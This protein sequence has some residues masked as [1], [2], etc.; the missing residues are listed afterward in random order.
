MKYQ[1]TVCGQIIDKNDVCPI[2]GSDSDKIFEIADEQ[3]PTMYR[4]LSC[5]RVFEN[6][7]VCPF[8]GG[9]E[10]YDLTND[11]IFD[12]NEKK[13]EEEPV[14][15][16]EEPID[17]FSQNLNE[18]ETFEDKTVDISKVTIPEEKEE[19]H[20]EI[21]EEDESSLI[22]DDDYENGDIIVHEAERNDEKEDV[23]LFGEEENTETLL[24][25]TISNEEIEESDPFEDLKLE[26][27]EEKE[28]EPQEKVEEETPLD[29]LSF[30]EDEV[31]EEVKEEIFEEPTIE[32][33]P[34]IE[35]ETEEEVELDTHVE[36][37]PIETDDE[38][39]V[40]KERRNKI[41]DQIIISSLSK[42]KDELD[43][44]RLSTVDALILNEVFDETNKVNDLSSDDLVTLF[45]E[46]Y[47][48]DKEIFEK[49][50]T[51]INGYLVF[52]DE[53]LLKEIEKGNK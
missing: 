47:A 5:G 38:I 27:E 32:E 52:K 28:E 46:K 18:E 39:D 30:T 4:C 15:V 41:I 10:L 17:L 1:C 22:Q 12:R 21:V 44:S 53:E 50:K 11:K 2:C 35:E 20:E 45:K 16:E 23:S 48:L 9:E 6:K 49:E 40:L 51:P 33:E 25:E 13:K 24:D 26:V 29:D 37:E 43:L 3:N 14:I 42:N 34:V 31:E 7:D 36:E 8:C 19:F